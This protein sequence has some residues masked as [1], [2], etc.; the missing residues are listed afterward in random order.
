MSPDPAMQN[1]MSLVRWS[2]R[3]AASTKYSGP[4][5]MVMRPRNVTTFSF[6]RWSGLG[7][8]A[9]SGLSG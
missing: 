6:P 2:T 5:C 9:A 4:F 1:R 8:A 7:R 3:L